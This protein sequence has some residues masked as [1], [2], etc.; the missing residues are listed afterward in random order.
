MRVVMLITSYHPIVGGAEKQ[1]AQVAAL[2]RAEGVEVHIVTR[3]H[4][5]LAAREDVGGAPVHRVGAAGLPKPLAAAAFLAGAVRRAVALKPDVL[6]CHSLWSPAV[7]GALARRLTGAPLVAK[8]MRG[9]EA[10]KI[11]GTPFGRTR[12]AW[13]TRAVD[14]FVVISREIDD[15][16]AGFGAPEARRVF[17]PNGVD[18]SRFEPADPAEKARLRARLDLPADAPVVVFAGRLTAQ[19]RLPLLLDAWA[20]VRAAAP[21]AL[22]LVAG[23][24]RSAGADDPG[25]IDPARLSAPGVRALG[26]VEDMPALLRAADVFALPSASEGLSNALLEACACGLAVVASR[27]GGAT[28][29]IETGRNGM[30]VDVDDRA[31]LCDALTALCRDR[32]LRVRLGAAARETVA[33]TY[34]VRATATSLLALYRSLRLAA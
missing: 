5:G 27:V 12:L 24:D 18:L 23:A 26:H 17:I 22:L 7:A 10:T 25:R 9:G 3:I 21:N 34:D 16:L 6:H 33:R 11:A 32:D 1:L 30:L 13:L 20:D 15:E 19:K 28:D 2:M 8:P 31:G 14:R 4:R 29:F